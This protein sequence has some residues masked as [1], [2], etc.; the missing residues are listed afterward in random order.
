MRSNCSSVNRRF[1]FTITGSS[2]RPDD[3]VSRYSCAAARSFGLTLCTGRAADFG[4]G[5]AISG[6]GGG[7]T[8][9]VGLGFAA[10]F[11]AAVR[12]AGTATL[13]GATALAAG[14]SFA[15]GVAVLVGFGLAS[16]GAGFALLG[17][18]GLETGL[19]TLRATDL[20]VLPVLFAAVFGRAGAFAL[21]TIGF[22]LF[23]ASTTS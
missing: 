13:A 4:T 3:R 19:L 10:V 20:T 14:F 22:N 2:L 6:D 1:P 23:Y 16:L 5:A 18:A 11:T 17:R 7:T 9:T 15:A 21:E 12:A 8:A